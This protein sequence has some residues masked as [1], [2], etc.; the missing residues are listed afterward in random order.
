MTDLPKG[1]SAGASA[2]GL[3]P[4]GAP[5]VALIVSDR[6]AAAVGVFT[7]NRVQAAPVAVTK[8]HL[9]RGAAR[10]IVANAGNANACTGKQGRADALEMAAVTGKLCGLKA[11][12]VLVASTGIIG[13]YMPME[14]LRAGI[15]DAAARRSPAGLE[16]AA[17]AIMTTDTR[18]KIATAEAGAARVVGIAKGAGM[19]APEMATMLAFVTTDAAADRGYLSEALG[20]A[21]APSFNMVSV[22]GCRSTNDTVLLLANG[23]A[24]GTP[25]EPGSPG[26]AEFEEALG[27]VC[28]SLARQMVEDGEGAT[29]VVTVRV[30]GAANAREA[31]AGARA[32]CDSVLMRA[33]LNAADPNWGRALAALGVA[34]IPL[35][36]NAIDLWL[37]GEKLCERG[38]P[39]PGDIDKAALALRE[40]EVELIADL[41]RGA[42]EAVMLT[43]DLSPEYV[44]LNAEYTT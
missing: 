38:A 10:A 23:A 17:S 34:G 4:S 22:D 6:P 9:R 28:A 35:D 20:R 14:K 26:A 32:I 13:R 40:R 44:R 30:R 43:N 8:S 33:A 11:K 37:G 15:G 16:A 29:K 3:K 12:D 19:I 24:G 7:T 27:E 18:P 25:I 2:C 42:T 31:R 21:V 39:G 41:G 1:F 36:P 5:D